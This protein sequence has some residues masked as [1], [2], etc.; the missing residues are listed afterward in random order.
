VAICLAVAC[1]PTAAPA[2]LPLVVAAAPLAQQSSGPTPHGRIVFVAGGDLWQWRDGSVHRLTTGERF[3]GPAWSPAGD[4]LAASVV[5]GNHSDLVLVS[6]EGEIQA[7]LTDHRG[8]ARIQDS[9][10]ARM[11]T[12]S[13]DGSRIAYVSDARTIDLAL[14]S[15][16]PDGRNPRQLY[17]APDT[18]GGVDRPTWSPDG[19]EIALAIWRPGPAQIEVFTAANGRTRRITNATNGA[20]DPAWSPDGHWIAHVVRDGSRHD[21]WIVHPD[22][23]RPTRVTSTGRNRMPAWSPD[24]RWLAFFSLSE[25]GFDVRVVSIP[26]EGEIEPAEGRVL[27]TGRPAEGPAGLTWAP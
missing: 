17:T 14:W 8:R 18:F 24:G 26:A 7:R 13:P 5:G 1:T 27:V 9:D 4:Q 21:V 23:S 16:G 20:Y 25:I 22:G 15:I 10:W 11:P 19:E 6:A 3:E 12:W 2:A